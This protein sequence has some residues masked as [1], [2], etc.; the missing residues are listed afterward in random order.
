MLT[1][2]NLHMG[3]C[4]GMQRR[5]AAILI[6]DVV[7]YS[8]LVEADEAGTLATLKERRRSVLDPTIRSHGGRVVKFMGDGVLVEFASAVNA[9][10]AAAE[11]QSRMAE[12]NTGLPQDRRIDLRIGINLGDVIGDG[13]DILGEGVNIAARLEAL[14]E[15]GGICISAKVHDEVRGKV[16][17]AFDDLGE[18]Q[19]KNIARP[20]RAFRHRPDAGPGLPVRPVLSLPDTPS[21]AVLPF[22]NMSGDPEQ[23][24]FADGMVEEIITALSRMR[25]L[26]VIARN[27]SFTYKGAPVDVK[28]V[29]RELGVRYV[30]QGSVRRAA[31]RVRIAGQLIDASTG[32]HLWADRFDG[33][34]ED[35]FDL[36]DR[37]T[38]SVVSAIAP[39]L[40]Q[41]EI[42]RATRKP[43]ESLGAYDYYLR[44]LPGVYLLTEEANTAAL[45]QF[46]RAIELDPRFASAYGMAARCY[47]QRVVCG[48]VK[49][50]PLE[51]AETRRLAERAAQLGHDDAVAL[52]TAALG[53]TFVCNLLE[54]SA[55]LIS[56]ALALNPNLALAWQFSGWTKVW[57]GE[58]E[59]AIEHVARAMRL[60]PNDPHVFNMQA[61][62]ACGH[63]FAGRDVEAAS[64]AE[65]TGR[66]QP[67]HV[68]GALI[69][70][71][72]NALIGRLDE[73]ER[74]IARVCQLDPNL[75]IAN[76]GE[77][78]PIRR[79]DDLAK[80]TEGL[81]KAGLPE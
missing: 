64:W 32:V 9:V 72:S 25:W 68:I 59:T 38:T 16:L 63:F 7:G 48:W 12:A 70:A 15:P 2:A 22:E 66:E 44:G 31:N 81:R 77:R 33:A 20:I 61:A 24:Y 62:T 14:A 50:R 57:L 74:A 28:R 55:I 54:E 18:Q 47:A 21:I 51:I 10:A 27:S 17:A 8:R 80:L 30:M 40:E 75:R 71:A 13:D 23:D 1:A 41:A 69:C 76:L 39:R 5:L 67:R 11:L 35:V 49:D 52:A 65:T 37:V 29:G 53:L 3:G 6:A 36:Q 73:A 34:V 4:R 45:Q 26:F 43:T 78:F 56:R 42:E 60:S 79:P 19:V 46:Y 58:P